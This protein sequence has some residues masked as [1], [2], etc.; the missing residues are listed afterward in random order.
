MLQELNPSPCVR[1]TVM[2]THIIRCAGDD[3]ILVGTAVTI[4]IPVAITITITIVVSVPTTPATTAIFDCKIR[5]AAVIYPNTS[6]I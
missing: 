4:T 2:P 5:P 6:A 3:L 1:L